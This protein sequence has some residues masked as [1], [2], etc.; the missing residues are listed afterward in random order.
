MVLP[1][2]KYLMPIGAKAM[3]LLLLLSAYLMSDMKRDYCLSFC[4]LLNSATNVSIDS[5]KFWMRRVRIEG[6]LLGT[7]SIPSVRV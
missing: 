4:S 3:H 7:L 1:Q 5:R 6:L 2:S